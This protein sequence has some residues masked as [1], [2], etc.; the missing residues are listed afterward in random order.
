M[1]AS[2]QQKCTA[3]VVLFWVYSPMKNQKKQKRGSEQGSGFVGEK[4]EGHSTT[5]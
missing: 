2:Q 5:L 3:A 4:R 1:A